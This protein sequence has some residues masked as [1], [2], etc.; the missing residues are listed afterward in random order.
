MNCSPHQVAA[1]LSQVSGK[2]ELNAE[3]KKYNREVAG[4]WL[5]VCVGSVVATGVCVFLGSAALLQ[6][7]YR[8][9][10]T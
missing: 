3:D 4:K 6:C 5:H 9:R 10:R 8:W 1:L 7:P 2:K